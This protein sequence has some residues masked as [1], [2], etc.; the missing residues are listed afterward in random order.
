LEGTGLK[1]RIILKWIFM[2]QNEVD[3]SYVAQ[4]THKLFAFLKTAIHLRVPENAGNF[5]LVDALSASQEVL[6]YV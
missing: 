4:D 1:W 5:G 6:K 2:E 3:G